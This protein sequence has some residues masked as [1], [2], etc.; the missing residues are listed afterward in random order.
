MGL[1]RVKKI[2]DPRPKGETILKVRDQRNS[3]PRYLP[4]GNESVYPN[5]N[6]YR[7]FVAMWFRTAEKWG[8]VKCPLS[9]EQINK[10]WSIIQWSI[11]QP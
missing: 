3:T 5:K 10:M 9:N 4:E 8:Q 2:L 7:M 11:I 6:S 1:P